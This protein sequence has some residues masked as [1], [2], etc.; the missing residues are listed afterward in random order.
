MKASIPAFDCKLLQYYAC[1]GKV[2]I[3][4]IA[5]ENQE[6]FKRAL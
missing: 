5:V 4:P 6:Y 2:A 3:I 1:F